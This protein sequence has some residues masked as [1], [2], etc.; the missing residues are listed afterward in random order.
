MTLEDAV[1]RIK[2]KIGTKVTLT[3]LRKGA[4]QP[5]VVTITRETVKVQSLQYKIINDHFAYIRLSFFQGPVDEDLNKALNDMLSKNKLQGIILDLRNNPGGLLDVSGRVASTFLDKQKTDQY[6]N[7][8]VYTKG[9][10]PG[11]DMEIKVTGVDKTNGLPM[12][13]LINEGSAS[14]SEIVAGALQDYHRAIIMGLAS[15]GKGSVQTVLPIDDGA[16]KLTTAL[17]YTPAG[18]VIQAKGIQPDVIV[19]QLEVSG[20][21]NTDILDIDEENYKNHLSDDSTEQNTQELL[22]QYQKERDTEM[23]LA[24]EDYQLFAAVMML[25]GISKI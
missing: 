8:V 10:I 19:P 22:I 25:K 4:D 23:Q 3:I 17:Y 5:I 20:K 12:V 14:A 7:L 18:R 11:S 15:F 24:K 2:G 21:E 1:N 9:R 16:I 13:V 6:N